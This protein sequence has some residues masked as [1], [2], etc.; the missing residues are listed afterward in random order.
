MKRK[1]DRDAYGAV[2]ELLTKK[3]HMEER[4]QKKLEFRR[5]E[6]QLRQKNLE[7][8]QELRREELKVRKEEL[9]LQVKREEAACY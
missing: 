3:M 9:A 4:Q 7:V 8:E 6:L 2:A 1:R 5:E